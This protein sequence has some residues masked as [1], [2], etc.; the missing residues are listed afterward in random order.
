MI[1]EGFELL[2]IMFLEILEFR[3]IYLLKINLLH[4]KFLYDESLNSYHSHIHVYRLGSLTFIF[5][6]CEALSMVR[7]CRSLGTGHAV[8]IEIH[9]YTLPIYVAST[10][11]VRIHLHSYI[12]TH[13]FCF[14]P[15]RTNPYIFH[16]Y[17]PR[18]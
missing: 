13:I 2:Y 1:W 16:S 14:Y 3:R 15:G 10:L 9:L 6:I 11:E 12:S 8:K 5:T 17:P 7:L 18:K 4:D